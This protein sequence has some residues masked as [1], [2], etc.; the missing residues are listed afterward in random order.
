MPVYGSTQ[1]YMMEFVGSVREA[2]AL[3]RVLELRG[4]TLLSVAR[5]DWATAAD[6]GRF[7]LTLRAST[8]LYIN[9]LQNGETHQAGPYDGQDDAERA[10]AEFLANATSPITD[11]YITAQRDHGRQY[12]GT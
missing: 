10:K 2:E 1:I 8:T 6:G 4:Y 5:S 12:V 3:A 7:L 9:Y 11:I